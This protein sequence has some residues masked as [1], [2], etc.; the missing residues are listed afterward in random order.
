MRPRLPTSSHE[1]LILKSLPASG[2]IHEIRPASG[3]AGSAKFLVTAHAQGDAAGGARLLSG[4]RALGPVPC[5]SRQSTASRLFQTLQA[6]EAHKPDW[7]E[8]ASAWVSGQIKFQLTRRL[9]KLRCEWPDLF[10][11]GDYQP[12]EVAGPHRGHVIAFSRQWETGQAVVAVGRHFGR[13]TNGG[14]DWP[15]AWDARL[16]LPPGKYDQVLSPLGDVCTGSVAASHLFA[17]LPV[18]VLLRR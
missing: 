14:R 10:Q 8:L 17:S 9:L 4:N 6:S 3:P 12:L 7:P 15:K 11:R 2:F 16:D 1:Y 5:R 13:V 18:N